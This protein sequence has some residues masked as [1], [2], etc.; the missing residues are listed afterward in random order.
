[1]TSNIIKYFYKNNNENM[2][3]WD[4]AVSSMKFIALKHVGKEE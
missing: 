4:K 1:M 2:T 3:Y